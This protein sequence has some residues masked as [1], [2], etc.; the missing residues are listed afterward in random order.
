MK[1]FSIKF[2]DSIENINNDLVSEKEDYF[3]KIDDF[4]RVCKKLRGTHSIISSFTEFILGRSYKYYQRVCSRY[5]SDLYS[6]TL[7][8]YA[9]AIKNKEKEYHFE[10]S[11][12]FQP[13]KSNKKLIKSLILEAMELI[14]NDQ[15]LTS[16][17]QKKIVAY[18]TKVLNELDLEKTNWSELLG[19]TKEIIIVLGALG[20]MTG[21]LVGAALALEKLETATEVIEKSSINGDFNSI[22]NIIQIDTIKSIMTRETVPTVFNL[23]FDDKKQIGDGKPEEEKD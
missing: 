8:L 22:S 12:F 10:L 11:G 13:N 14:E 20:S 9:N 3:N 15:T 4:L 5:H 7:S 21:G 1:S 18:L 23:G 6:S 17:S 16:K 2:Y 19:R